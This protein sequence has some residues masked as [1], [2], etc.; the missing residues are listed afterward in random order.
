VILGFL[1]LVDVA[2]F[3][4]VSEID[5]ISTFSVDFGLT[6]PLGEGRGGW[7]VETSR[8]TEQERIIKGTVA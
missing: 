6:E 4:D 2:N 7:P 1:Q 8:D 3:I 5:A